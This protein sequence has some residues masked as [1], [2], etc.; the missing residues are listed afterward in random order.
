MDMHEQF[1]ALVNC[2]VG[3]NISLIPPPPRLGANKIAPYR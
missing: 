1:A 3:R 2:F